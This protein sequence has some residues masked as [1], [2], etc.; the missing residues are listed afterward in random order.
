M[1]NLHVQKICA[2]DKYAKIAALHLIVNLAC[3]DSV[4]ELKMFN[5]D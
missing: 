5:L 3:Y 4:K 1:A 2:I